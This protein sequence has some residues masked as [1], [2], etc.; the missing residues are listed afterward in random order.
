MPDAQIA[1]PAG[2][3][4]LTA[5]PSTIDVESLQNNS[6]AT[7]TYGDVVVIDATGTQVNTTTTANDKTVIGVVGQKAA[8]GVGA[9]AGDGTTYAAAAIMPVVVRGIARINIGTTTVAANDL[10]TTTTTAGVATTNAGAPAANAVTGS[11]IGV[12]LEA[13]GAKDSNN[14]IRA[15]IQKF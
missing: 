5:S 3:F 13:S 14:T 7:R 1:N 8:G 11:L 2:V 6:G 9:T 15:W 10:L 12:A 4:G